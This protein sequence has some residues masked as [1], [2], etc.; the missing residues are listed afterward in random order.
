MTPPATT[1]AADTL[2]S[3]LIK[4]CALVGWFDPGKLIAT[5]PDDQR[6]EALSALAAASEEYRVGDRM[7]WR[8]TPEARRATLSRLQAGPEFRELLRTV[9]P[10]KGDTFGRSLIAALSKREIDVSE[11]AHEQLQ[12]FY[13]AFEFA[14]LV[15][16]AQPAQ[17]LAS[18]AN[19][20]RGVLAEAAAALPEGGEAPR[21]SGTD[22]IWAE[23]GRRE[24]DA[25]LASLS[26]FFLG[27]DAEID[28]IRRY[29]G[30]GKIHVPQ[31]EPEWLV[32]VG[33]PK[34]E[35]AAAVLVTGIGGV[36]KSAVMSQLIQSERKNRWSGVPIVVLDFDR[37]T[38]A[39][40]DA[41]EMTA[42]FTRQLA[43]AH[44]AEVS[45]LLSKFRVE[46]RQDYAQVGSS[47]SSFEMAQSLVASHL[48]KL[49]ELL[50]GRSIAERPVLLLVDTFEEVM[51]R[52]PVPTEYVLRWAAELK[53]TAG[54][55]ALRVVLAGRVAPHEL[56]AD[57]KD[58]IAAHIELKDLPPD[59]AE[60]VLQGLLT[61]AG[62]SGQKKR[63]TGK[64]KALPVPTAKTLAAQLVK[65]FGGNP[66]VLRIL[67]QYCSG[68]TAKQIQAFADEVSQGGKTGSS[69]AFA[70]AFLYS[71]ILERVEDP[72]IRALAYPGLVLRRVTK[73]IVRD[74]LAEPCGLGD[75]DDKRAQA[76]LSDLSKYVWLV[77][78][79]PDGSVRHRPDLRRL[80]LPI[81]LGRREPVDERG[82]ETDGEKAKDRKERIAKAKDINRR[83]I[84][85]YA[86]REMSGNREAAVER[87]Y[88]FLLKDDPPEG[89]LRL[90]PP[91]FADAI[92][93]DVDSLDDKAR[94]FVKLRAGRELSPLEIELLPND[95]KDSVLGRRAARARKKGAT[96]VRLKQDTPAES[97]APAPIAADP[98]R[99]DGDLPPPDDVSAAF[100]EGD[101]EK[102]S[103]HLSRC[104]MDATSGFEYVRSTEAFEGFTISDQWRIFLAALAA[105]PEI[106]RHRIMPLGIEKRLYEV[107]S[108]PAQR[109]RSDH[110]TSATFLFA[111][112]KAFMPERVAELAGPFC[113][114]FAA[115]A[116]QR[117]VI[118][119]AF[120]LRVILLQ[121]GAAAVS[122]SRAWALARINDLS[123]L[124]YLAMLPN[125][126]GLLSN[127]VSGVL[128][129]AD[130]LQ[131]EKIVAGPGAPVGPRGRKDRYQRPD[132]P[133]HTY[134]SL[135]ESKPI[136]V[137]LTESRDVATTVRL[138]R[139]RTPEL[140]SPLRVALQ[141]ELDNERIAD[142]ARELAGRAPVWPKQ[143]G[144]ER[145]PSALK[146]D[147]GTWI[148]TLIEFADRCGLLTDVL[149]L[150]ADGS[151]GAD[152][153]ISK[154]LALLTA[155]DR[156]LAVDPV[157]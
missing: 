95:L 98:P 5:V 27:R 58:E 134:T 138:L 55:Q 15:S 121:V 23:I 77:S 3:D 8:L 136:T 122:Q 67:D 19:K 106:G 64:R 22:V 54:L 31:P 91:S 56:V 113:K 81:L 49:G 149:Q 6:E 13:R 20:G 100:A 141:D 48:S 1:A 133:L 26:S 119:D 59:I 111:V 99:P 45:T 32:H 69:G 24:S 34:A 73:D 114:V 16:Y 44:D 11:L 42:E 25:A 117:S 105:P 128:G 94:A 39:S 36:G 43:L 103:S 37:P 85:Y 74:I 33:A 123:L 125:T 124:N 86:E 38:L 137:D 84:E 143:L 132:G 140:Y 65:T 112:L 129:P 60:D 30:T 151:R 90:I 50:K 152:Q 28:L 93:E 88:H 148:S 62:Q 76:L 14:Q 7:C 52:G 131:F 53:T 10:E 150:A 72:T 155:Y 87:L 66:L 101:F 80:M 109:H 21:P 29:V 51:V 75:V 61:D 144:A 12:E 96:R 154:L 92:G 156:L 120:D 145:L 17:V 108:E 142:V 157:A 146:R 147:R 127:A 89:I 4:P 47:G 40:A 46:L 135:K 79:E 9:K 63:R 2:V 57:L 107:L 71:R 126:S 78:K 68:K 35:S 102:L 83:A 115:A 116:P 70:Q 41:V 153:R 130:R 110:F 82:D 18:D 104:V 118:A 139:G 97:Q